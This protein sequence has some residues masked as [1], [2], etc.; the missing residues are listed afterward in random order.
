MERLGI[1]P[2]NIRRFSCILISCIFY[3]MVYIAIFDA[4]SFNT[5]SHN[6]DF[7]LESFLISK[8]KLISFPLFQFEACE[9]FVNNC[10]IKSHHYPGYDIFFLKKSKSARNLSLQWN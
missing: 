5:C 9:S 7:K 2:S 10:Y 6:C 8:L 3:G 4:K 1:I